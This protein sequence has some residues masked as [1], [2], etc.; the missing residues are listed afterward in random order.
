MFRSIPLKYLAQCNPEVLS[1][2]TDPTR[3]IQYV[4]IGNVSAGGKVTSEA[5][6]FGEAPSRARRTVRSGDVIVSTV[7]TYLRAIAHL[8][9]APDNLVVSTG[10]A[11]LRPHSNVNSRFFGYALQADDFVD[12]VVSQSDGV[13]YP[14][15]TPQKLTRIPI[16]LPDLQTQEVIADYLTHETA[17]ADALT[18]DFRSLLQALE[19]RRLAMISEAVTRG[20][21]P[22]AS[23]KESGVEWIADIPV[24]SQ[25]S[26]VKYVTEQIGSGFTPKG[27]A[28]I[29]QDSGITFIRSQ[30]VYD[31]GLRL[32]DV[33]YVAPEIDAEM[34]RTRVRKNDVLL[35][36]TG[37]SI[38]R[39]CVVDSAA[40][41]ANVNQHVCIV[42]PSAAIDPAY[43]AF[44]L[45]S[46]VVKQQI[47]A[48]ENGS[49]RE[50]LNYSQVGNLIIVVPDERSE[51]IRIVKELASR[52]H[53]LDSLTADARRA[54]GLILEQRSALISA[55][56]TG[57]IDVSAYESPF[58]D[59]KVA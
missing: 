18:T 21:N 38:G 39:T 43:L 4:D 19:Q 41:P 2:E 50:G 33:I 24:S 37:A 47:L 6:L 52:L 34:A 7:R 57:Q 35:N 54:L 22:T 3:E 42:R 13:S 58:R 16:P 15:I 46:H 20:V 51:Q 36:I 12:N 30:N 48:I 14:A 56:V 59:R 26:K 28:E 9:N 53:E 8:D 11:V 25:I 10:F 29:Y 27:G 5:M 40:L 31:D 1:E 17:G 23:M 45:K 44:C 55:A 49:S 32:D